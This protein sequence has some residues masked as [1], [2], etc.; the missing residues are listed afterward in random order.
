MPGQFLANSQP[1]V[2]AASGTNNYTAYT[3][4]VN[5]GSPKQYGIN[6]TYQKDIN[7][8]QQMDAKYSQRFDDYTYYSN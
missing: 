7:T 1:D 4:F 6:R 5:V 3:I 2:V 8:P